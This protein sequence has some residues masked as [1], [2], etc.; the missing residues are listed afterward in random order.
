MWSIY[1]RGSTSLLKKKKRN[2]KN[3][4]SF[5]PG[6]LQKLIQLVENVF[7][8]AMIHVHISINTMFFAKEE[9]TTIRRRDWHRILL[10]FFRLMLSEK[11]VNMC[12]NIPMQ[13][14]VIKQK[15]FKNTLM[16][17]PLK[18]LWLM[19]KLCSTYFLTNQFV[20]TQVTSVCD[21]NAT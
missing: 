15:K 14:P 6:N 16:I 19:V 20:F 8:L 21:L 4:V 2:F 12:K 7:S 18:L 11:S 3:E 10:V 9:I 17:L 1:L 13:V 5:F